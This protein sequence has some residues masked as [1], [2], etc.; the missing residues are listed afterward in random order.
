MKVKS[1]SGVAQSCPTLCDPMVLGLVKLVCVA[2][3][4][5]WLLCALL[6]LT[7]IEFPIVIFCNSSSDRIKSRNVLPLYVIFIH[8]ILF[9]KIF[10]S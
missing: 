5:H 9:L 7:H 1:E 3:H 6:L 10:F 2:S 8:I 4:V